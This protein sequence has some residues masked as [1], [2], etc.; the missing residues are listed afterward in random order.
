MVNGYMQ[1]TMRLRGH[2]GVDGIGNDQ[3]CTGRGQIWI[4]E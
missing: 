2:I 4:K 1:Y 3:G